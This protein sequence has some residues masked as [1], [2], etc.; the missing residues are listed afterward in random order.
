MLWLWTTAHDI[1][2]SSKQHGGLIQPHLWGSMLSLNLY[3]KKNLTGTFNIT[4]EAIYTRREVPSTVPLPLDTLQHVCPVVV[5]MWGGMGG[6]FFY[7]YCKVC[8]WICEFYVQVSYK[9]SRRHR[10]TCQTHSL[11]HQLHQ[12]SLHWVILPR[13][14]SANWAL[15]QKTKPD[16]GCFTVTRIMYIAV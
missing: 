14:Y 6:W 8:F 9:K 16:R 5:M 12:L 1:N 3:R 11:F 7:C 13:L 2:L 4:V 15:R 10:S